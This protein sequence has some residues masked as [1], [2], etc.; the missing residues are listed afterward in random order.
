MGTRDTHSSTRAGANPNPLGKDGFSA[1]MVAAQQHKI[2]HV[3]ALCEHG[4][5]I[6]IGRDSFGRTAL[7]MAALQSTGKMR[8]H[9][10]G[11]ETVREA[12]ASHKKVHEIISKHVAKDM[13]WLLGSKCFD[14]FDLVFSNKCY[15]SHF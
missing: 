11:N 3:E 2:Q 4:A 7:D 15:S 6:M 13:P 10:E 8:F 1:L 9:R 14:K 12:M 5:T